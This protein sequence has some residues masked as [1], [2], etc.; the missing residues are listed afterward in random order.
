VDECA[1]RRLRALVDGGTWDLESLESVRVLL[2][3]YS[4]PPSP[5]VHYKY[6]SCVNSINLLKRTQPSVLE[7][8]YPA[9]IEGDGNCL[10]R[11]VSLIL[12]ASQQYHGYLRAKTAYE[13]MRNRDWYDVQSPNC[14][15][16]L[17]NVNEIVLA[18]YSIV[19]KEVIRSRCSCD[20]TAI[21]ALSSVVGL[22]IQMFWPPLRGNLFLNRYHAQFM[23]VM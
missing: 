16:T 14:K 2:L 12:Y 3:G 13:V 1:L 8:L 19:L 4:L 11:S 17:L 18:N 5:V 20:V 21:L 15:H 23:V 22:P 6:P 9:K 7:T 10:F